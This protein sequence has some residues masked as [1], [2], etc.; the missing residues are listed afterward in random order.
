LEVDPIA[1][2][3]TKT[4][5]VDVLGA[6][7]VETIEI[8]AGLVEGMLPEVL[9]ECTVV[10]VVGV[11]KNDVA[12]GKPENHITQFI[13]IWSSSSESGGG[14][15]IPSVISW[16]ERVELGSVSMISRYFSELSNASRFSRMGGSL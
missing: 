9:I 15:S 3:A 6:A 12:P 4:S 7:I 5:K 13:T 2:L 11:V 16:R 10:E 8:V 1:F 14:N